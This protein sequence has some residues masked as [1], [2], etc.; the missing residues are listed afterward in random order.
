M[1]VL[2]TLSEWKEINRATQQLEHQSLVKEYSDNME[3]AG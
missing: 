1:Y 2:C 3:R